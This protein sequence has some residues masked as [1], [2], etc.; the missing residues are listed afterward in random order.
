MFGGCISGGNHSGRRWVY[1]LGR[2]GGRIDLGRRSVLNFN[3]LIDYVFS[4]HLAN[5]D[6]L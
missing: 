4:I 3:A 2:F 1:W 5:I 6:H